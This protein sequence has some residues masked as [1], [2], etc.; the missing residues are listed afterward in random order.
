MLLTAE[1]FANLKLL[2]DALDAERQARE[3]QPKTKPG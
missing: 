2:V 3:A 1:E